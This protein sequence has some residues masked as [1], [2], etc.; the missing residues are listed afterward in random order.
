MAMSNSQREILVLLSD[1][2]ERPTSSF[3]GF[4]D[5]RSVGAPAADILVREGWATARTVTVEGGR[6]RRFVRITDAG[7]EALAAEV[8]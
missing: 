3:T 6:W 5:P 4:G 1:G 7:R 8:K 2:E